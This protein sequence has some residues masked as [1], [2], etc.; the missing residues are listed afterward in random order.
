MSPHLA[1]AIA[2]A[3]VQAHRGSCVH[4]L[5]STFGFPLT[6]L[7]LRRGNANIL[8]GAARAHAVWNGYR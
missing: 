3:Q 7:A 5:D 2:P 6:R 8:H 4:A 1:R